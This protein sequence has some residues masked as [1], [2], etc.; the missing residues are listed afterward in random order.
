MSFIPRTLVL[1]L[2]LL[3]PLAA[4]GRKTIFLD[5][6]AGLEP[7]VEK[8]ALDA[9]LPL[10]F[11]E[12]AEHPDLKV[13]LGNKFSSVHAEVLYR[14]NTGRTDNTTLEVIDMKTR[15]SLLV[16]SFRWPAEEEGRKRV[17]RDFVSRL[18]SVIR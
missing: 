11:L 10:E 7:Y 17:A 6:M 18:K 5:R 1:C 8:A 9:E 16:F 15:E 2:A 3:L 14:K 13:L 12:E 4:V